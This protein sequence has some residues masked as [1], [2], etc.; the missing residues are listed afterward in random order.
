MVL[1]KN[2]AL[3]ERDEQGKL[4]P[5]EVELVVDESVEEQLPYKGEKIVMIPL[6]R[7]EIRKLFSSLEVK[8]TDSDED[9]DGDLIIKHCVNPSFK[10]EDKPYLKGPITTV[11]VN[12]I[13]YHSGIDI[14]KP[15][16]SA[17]RDK[18]DEF[19]KN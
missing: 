4:I 6:L 17:L 1:S 8:K 14:T 3:F 5:K 7:G 12:T 15:R 13:L 10:E 9:I 19:G 18:E 11:L 2:R 16:R